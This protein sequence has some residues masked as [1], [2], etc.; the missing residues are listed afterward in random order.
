M[1]LRRPSFFLSA[2]CFRAEVYGCGYAPCIGN[3]AQTERGG[4]QRGRAAEGRVVW[5]GSQRQQKGAAAWNQMTSAGDGGFVAILALKK[6]KKQRLKRGK[7]HV[8]HWKIE[9]GVVFRFRIF[10]SFLR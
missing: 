2:G 4:G 7:T 9:M 6:Q 8:K 10:C 5:R 3:E 1:R